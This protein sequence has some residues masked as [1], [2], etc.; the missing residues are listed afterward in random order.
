MGFLAIVGIPPKKKKGRTQYKPPSMVEQKKQGFGDDGGANESAGMEYRIFCGNE[1]Y[2]NLEKFLYIKEISSDYATRLPTHPLE[3]GTVKH[4]HKIVEPRTYTAQAYVRA[5]GTEEDRTQAGV[6]IECSRILDSLIQSPSLDDIIYIESPM[7]N[8]TPENV[9]NGKGKGLQLYLTSYSKR[10]ESDKTDVFA[11]TLNLQE[12]LIANKL[13]NVSDNADY[14]GESVKGGL[15][16][17][18]E[19]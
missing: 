1:K 17:G 16:Q 15:G 5:V 10:T 7:E 19:G 11:F 4:D 18:T 14:A 13:N 2:K 9:P 8:V 6:S 3:N 12:I